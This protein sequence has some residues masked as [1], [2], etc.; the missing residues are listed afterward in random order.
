MAD[1]QHVQFDRSITDK[2]TIRMEVWTAAA[3]GG[4]GKKINEIPIQFPP[5]VTDNKSM[6]WKE[7]WQGQYEP[8]AVYKS[9][10]ARKLSVELTYIA[11]GSGQFSAANIAKYMRQIRGVMM[12]SVKEGLRIF[13]RVTLDLWDIVP[14]G[15][16]VFRMMDFNV[17]YGDTVVKQGNSVYPLKTTASMNLAMS[18]LL[19]GKQKGQL[20]PMKTSWY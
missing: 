14:E 2:D 12:Y 5:K 13:P 8:V 10:A 15:P 20:P 1:P 6:E 17:S 3:P 4:P 9:S 16:A 18:S 11:T 7:I 19:G